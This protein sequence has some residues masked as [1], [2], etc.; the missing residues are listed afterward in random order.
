[1]AVPPHRE[2][3]FISVKLLHPP[4]ATTMRGALLGL[5]ALHALV[6]RVVPPVGRQVE[7]NR[8]ACLTW[9]GLGPGLRLGFQTLALALT[10][11]LANPSPNPK[12][13]G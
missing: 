13:P 10:L 8:D 6:V 7:G 1:M 9:L 5:V 2:H 3:K 4:L 12:P 11:P